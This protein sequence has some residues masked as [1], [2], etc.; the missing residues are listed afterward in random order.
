MLGMFGDIFAV[1]CRNTAHDVLDHL[2]ALL[3]GFCSPMG[4]HT[5][6]AE[7]LR[8]TSRE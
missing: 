5:C 8:D 4:V 2:T 7:L 3:Q 1:L 6:I